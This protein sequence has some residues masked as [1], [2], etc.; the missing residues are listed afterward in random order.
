MAVYDLGYGLMG[1]GKF[2]HFGSLYFVMANDHLSTSGAN[3]Q[4]LRSLPA[5]KAV[6]LAHFYLFTFRPNSSFAVLL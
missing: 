4:T 1:P 2:D 6:A 5:K 3:Y